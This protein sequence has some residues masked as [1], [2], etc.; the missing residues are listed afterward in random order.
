MLIAG[1]RCKLPRGMKDVQRLP[2]ADAGALGNAEACGSIVPTPEE[3]GGDDDPREPGIGIR[4]TPTCRLGQ[5]ATLAPRA[6]ST[7]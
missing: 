7:L 4:R 5:P 1:A 6:S 3:G 2:V